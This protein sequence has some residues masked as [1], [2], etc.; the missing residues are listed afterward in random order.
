MTKFQILLRAVYI[1]PSNSPYGR[2]P[3]LIFD[4]TLVTAY[5]V[6]PNMQISIGDFNSRVGNLD[7][8]ASETVDVPPQKVIETVT[9][10]FFYYTK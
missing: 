5:E 6:V 2:D 4:K 10:D 7:N 3:S 8:T 1:P 9:I